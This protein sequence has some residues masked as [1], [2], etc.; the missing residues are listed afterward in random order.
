[1]ELLYGIAFFILIILSGF[2]S[3]AETA[4]LTL[5]KIKLNL[6]AKKK[7]KRAIILTRILSKPDELI[8]TILIGNNFVNIAAATIS[9]ALAT[10][11][12]NGSEG[13]IL[14][15][16]SLATTIVVLI[17][18]EIMPKSFAY[19]Y[20]ET[21]SNFYAYP[22]EF[23]THLFS[24]FVRII[25]LLSK[26]IFKRKRFRGDEKDLSVE[27]IKHFLSSETKHFQYH[28]DALHMVHE[29]IDIVEKDIK[30]IMTPRLNTIA[31]DI[32]DGLAGLKRIIIEKKI[33]NI[34]V[35]DQTLDNIVGVIHNEDILS[36]VMVGRY[37]DIDLSQI[38]R[39]PVFVSEYSSLLYVLKE[40]KKFD[41]DIAIVV[42]EY[43]S[44]IGIITLSHI[45]KQILG[46][47]KIGR[48]PI[49]KIGKQ[50]FIIKGDTPVEEVNNQLNLELPVKVDYTTM[51]G[52]FIYYFGKFPK[53][54]SKIKIK[55][56]RFIVRRM[57]KRMVEEMVLVKDDRH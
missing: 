4:L 17:F 55:K 56:H 29:I 7:D 15:I 19:R 25:T 51:S 14:V 34:P 37:E 31:L 13:I 33:A 28:P 54:G 22:I 48:V 21:L 57:G 24:P 41:L 44:T 6:K 49:K 42:D 10:R 2:F 23:L 12:I 50:A 30:A 43:G 45:F 35:Y 39:T 16:S 47:L 46:E 40:F 11:L 20:N 38:M 32:K 27:E 53:E 8:S 9:T 5:N 26:A 18:S 1:M 36:V 52:F 3:S